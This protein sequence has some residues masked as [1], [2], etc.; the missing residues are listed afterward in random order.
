[1]KSA[2]TANEF[3]V[4][5]TREGAVGALKLVMILLAALIFWNAASAVNAHLHSRD[6][7]TAPPFLRGAAKLVIGTETTA[8]FHARLHDFWLKGHRPF[9]LVVMLVAIV[10]LSARFLAT[11]RV[12]DY[13]YLE[14]E[15]RDQRIYSGFVANIFL[16]LVHAG[17]IYGLVVV[18]PGEHASLA[19][20]TM[21]VLFLM[22]LVWIGFVFF[23]SWPVER[24]ALRGLRYM[25]FTTAAATVLLFAL[26]WLI[27]ERPAADP[28]VRGSQMIL[29]AAGVAIALCI[30]DAALQT[31]L[32]FPRKKPA[33]R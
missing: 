27:E 30:A 26:T 32:Y 3:H 12:L 24:H 33:G 14:S 31:A 16:S 10:L 23:T 21:L 25:A 28:S 4:A 15:C 8:P 17:L 11:G 18:D 7:V 13:L 29:L 9:A 6:L 1:M 22:N 20:V 5:L 19:P 2:A